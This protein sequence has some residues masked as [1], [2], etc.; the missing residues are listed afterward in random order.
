MLLRA[1]RFVLVSPLGSFLVKLL[2]RVREVAGSQYRMPLLVR[3]VQNPWGQLVRVLPPRV[4]QLAMLEAID[5]LPQVRLLSEF[6][7]SVCIPALFPFIL[8]IL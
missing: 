7:V 3:Q 8:F 6:Q 4:A 1:E 2:L 5:G